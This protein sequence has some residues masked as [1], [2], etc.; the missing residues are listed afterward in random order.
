MT[1]LGDLLTEVLDSLFGRLDSNTRYSLCLVSK[2]VSK[3][4]M[5]VFYKHVSVSASLTNLPN[6]NLPPLWKLLSILDRYPEMLADVKSFEFRELESTAPTA[7]ASFAS[8]LALRGDRTVGQML[9]EY[10]SWLHSLRF[11]KMLQK[12]ILSENNLGALAA[13]LLGAIRKLEEF[14]V[15]LWNNS[16]QIDI[17]RVLARSGDNN[18]LQCL[19]KIFIEGYE[20]SATRNRLMEIVL[21]DFVDLPSLTEVPLRNVEL[22]SF[23]TVVSKLPL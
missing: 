21:S 4:A 5:G 2:H 11:D 23:R 7:P 10:S 13:V 3:S 14:T 8:A 6:S 18:R 15:R 1:S 20:P 9:I 19:K 12:K 17:W 22:F 16:T